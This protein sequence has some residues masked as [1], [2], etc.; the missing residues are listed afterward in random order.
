MIEKISH[1]ITRKPR[2]ILLLALLL[3][4]PSAA[5]MAATRINYDILSY[6]PPDLESSKG[7]T[8]LEEPF[9]DA[10]VSM[11]IVED[12]P[13]AYSNDLLRTVQDIPGVSNAI[14]IS[15]LVGIQIPTDMIPENLRDMFYSGDSTMMIIQYEKSGGS[16]ETMAAI[17]QVRAACN[18]QCFLAGISVMTKD[19]K[20]L[21]EAELPVYILLA[22]GLSLVAMAFTLESWLLPVAFL[23][24]IGIAILYNFGTNIFLGEISYITQA[25]AAV[26]QLGV[27]MDYSIFLYHRYQEEQGNYP[28]KRDAMAAAIQ[29]AFT[30]VSGSS[31][32]TIAGFL[33]L[34][35]MQLLLGRDIGIVMA[36]GVAL[37]VLTVILVL[38]AL[39]LV[40]DKP[41]EACRHRSFIPSFERLNHFVIRHRKGFLVLFVL[42]FLPA[43]YAQSHADIYYKL[44]QALPQDMDSITANNKLKQE[45]NMAS[46]HFVIL[47]DSLTSTQMYAM[48]EQIEALPGVETVISYHK[49]LHS[50]IPDF[51]IPEDLSGL[52]RQEGMQLMMINSSYE[53]ASEEVSQQLAAL[54]RIVKSYDPG[55]YITGEAAMTDDLVT[56][57]NVDFKL[58]NYISI[59]AILIIVAIVFRSFTVPVVLVLAIEL[60][61]FINQGVPYFTGT[62]IPFISPTVISCV[63]L[64][65]TVDYAILMTTRFQ[66]ELRGGKHR[67]EAIQIAATAAA[68][69]IVTSSIV[70]FCAT[71]GVTMVSKIELI[72]NICGMLARGALISAAVSICIMPPLLCVCEPLFARTSLHWRGNPQKQKTAAPAPTPEEALSGKS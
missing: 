37:G 47:D 64:G 41:I 57:S 71:L 31:A 49:L 32:T 29:A 63:Q 19:I 51:F 12:M 54:D 33:A 26:L 56:T 44:D 2:F 50:G 4:I 7:E 55:A 38:P 21:V 45:Y 9:H 1:F 13:P 20:D 3:L 53:N 5:G 30:S 52:V 25:I 62:A 40:F 42:L 67:L 70:M 48:E 24:S 65:A 11:L 60:A 66:E 23:G 69:S 36:K 59:A 17:D 68:P 14:W 6:L 34:C 16:D 61:I 27:T 46:S 28:D 58:T 39:L 22:A 72:S 8:L 15:N 10:A 18:K 43:L 35:F